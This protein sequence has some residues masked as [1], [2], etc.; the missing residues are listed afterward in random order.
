MISIVLLGLMSVIDFIK[1]EIHILVLLPV[2]GIWL[3]VSVYNNGLKMQSI[4]AA[5]V[6]VGLS[7][8]TR[9]A[10]GLAD[11]IILGLIS[12]E[13]GALR[14]LL[15]FFTANIIFLVFAGIKYGFRQR[16]REIPFIPFI[17]IA[18]IIIK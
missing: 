5:A 10:F 12:V 8:A 18:F 9:Q 15:I 16:K 2:I 11:A 14:M 13:A 17:F 6:L 1:K 4:M 7:L 3:G